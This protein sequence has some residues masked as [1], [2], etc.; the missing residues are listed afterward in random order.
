MV[1]RGR[2]RGR[3]GHRRTSHPKKPI[4]QGIGFFA[5]TVK[6]KVHVKVEATV[7][8]RIMEAFPWLPRSIRG[9]NINEIT[10]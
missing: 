6:I 10:A 2:P 9:P 7:G 4:P 3:V 5:F 8:R 1:L